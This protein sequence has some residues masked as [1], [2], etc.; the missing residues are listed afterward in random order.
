MRSLHEA[1]GAKGLAILALPSSQ[2]GGQEFAKDADIKVRAPEGPVRRWER[3]I[4][5]VRWTSFYLGT[6]TEAEH[7]VCCCKTRPLSL[8]FV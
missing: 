4:S 3:Q 1:H 2:F 7:A 8:V 5:Y 6:Q